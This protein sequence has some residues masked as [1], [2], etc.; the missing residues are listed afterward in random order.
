MTDS[1]P[2]PLQIVLESDIN[3]DG[4]LDFQEFSQYLRA[5]EKRLRLM[6]HNLDRNNDGVYLHTH[7]STHTHISV[8]FVIPTPPP[9]HIFL[10]LTV[11]F[12]S[13]MSV[14]RTS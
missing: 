9:H 13:C 8:H 6:F 5:H 7:A 1:L 14:K 12:L 2:L 3:H 11:L 4:L 10:N